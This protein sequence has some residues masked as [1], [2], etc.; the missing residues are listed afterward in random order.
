MEN[1]KPIKKA[2]R[3]VIR[4]PNG[5][6]GKIEEKSKKTMTENF[7]ELIRCQIRTLNKVPNKIK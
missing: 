4:D 5:K 1:L 2:E 3:Y 6:E 7:A